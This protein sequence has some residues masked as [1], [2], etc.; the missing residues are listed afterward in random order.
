MF[1][2]QSQTLLL[3]SRERRFSQ[4]DRSTAEEVVLKIIHSKCV[5]IFLYGLDACTLKKADLESL[6]FA[7]NCFFIKLFKTSNLDTV[8]YC[9]EQ[10]CFELPSVIIASG[11]TKF[12]VMF[13]NFLWNK[14][15]KVYPL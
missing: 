4:I 14:Y 3:L 1:N 2:K 13:G 15:S 12:E 6:D 7:I 9:Q 11:K 8:W 10:F 5:P